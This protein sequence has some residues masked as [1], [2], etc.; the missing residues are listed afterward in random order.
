MEQDLSFDSNN[1]DESN[2]QH[3]QQKDTCKL[4]NYYVLCITTITTP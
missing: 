3:S 2:S 4:H 1:N